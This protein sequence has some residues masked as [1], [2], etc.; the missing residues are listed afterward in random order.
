MDICANL[1]I[2]NLDI[3]VILELIHLREVMATKNVSKNCQYSRRKF[4]DT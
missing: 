2:V 3:N 4:Q 1:E